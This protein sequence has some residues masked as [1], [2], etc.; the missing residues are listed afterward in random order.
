MKE[1]K[2]MG[3]VHL[4]VEGSQVGALSETLPAGGIQVTRQTSDGDS[5]RMLM[6]MASQ[7][8]W[9]DAEGKPY[10][11]TPQQIIERWWSGITQGV[12]DGVRRFEQE[13][14][15]KAAADAVKQI[16]VT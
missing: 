2:F 14:A 6:W 11:P 4:I 15:A 16:N 13:Q 1:K 5:A 7:Y 10:A 3:K 9:L 12:I 8:E